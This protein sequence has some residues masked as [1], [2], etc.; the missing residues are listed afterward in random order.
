MQTSHMYR[1]CYLYVYRLNIKR[2]IIC[3]DSDDRFYIL[4]CKIYILLFRRVS[5][6]CHIR[7]LVFRFRTYRPTFLSA[8]T[9][10]SFCAATA[11]QC[12]NVTVT[13]TSRMHYN[14]SPANVHRRWRV[15]ERAQKMTSYMI[16]ILLAR[17]RTLQLIFEGV[18][19]LLM[20]LLLQRNKIC[21]VLS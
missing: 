4:L 12:D 15:Q 7:T 9:N 1:Y 16:N 17:T 11:R 8:V 19:R 6:A 10:R 5:C 2:P 18:H 14:D 21:F 3:R 20:K 13:Y